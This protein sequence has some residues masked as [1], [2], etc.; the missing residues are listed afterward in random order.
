VTAELELGIA[1]LQRATRTKPLERGDVVEAGLAQLWILT[2]ELRAKRLQGYGMLGDGERS[3][4]DEQA[5]SLEKKVN[6][7][8]SHIRGLRADRGPSR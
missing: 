3:F 4:L 1:E 6:A 8:R 7:L 2:C 5:E